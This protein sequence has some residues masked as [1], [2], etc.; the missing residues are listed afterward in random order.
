MLEQLLARVEHGCRCTA[1]AVEIHNESLS[2]LLAPKPAS[3]PHRQPSKG[4]PPLRLREDASRGVYVAN[5]T[6]LELTSPEQAAGVLAT[7]LSSRT[8]GQT[9]MNKQSSRSHAVTLTLALTP[10]P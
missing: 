6:S 4:P 2:D 8:V 5:V 9:A 1:T 3:E 10:R 7:V